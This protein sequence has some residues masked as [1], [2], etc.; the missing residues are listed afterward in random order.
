[1]ALENESYMSFS[2]ALKSGPPMA[3]LRVELSR[4]WAFNPLVKF[5]LHTPEGFHEWKKG[6]SSLKAFFE[7]VIVSPNL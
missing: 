6:G 5:S 3:D 2:W 7:C 1:M 4:G